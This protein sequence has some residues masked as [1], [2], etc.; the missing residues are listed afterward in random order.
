M[1]ARAFAARA[2]AAARA[3]PAFGARVAILVALL[4]LVLW[5]R[6]AFDHL[7]SLPGKAVLDAIEIKLRP[8][9]SIDLGWRELGQTPGPR[10]AESR[11]VRFGF[12]NGALRIANVARARR[13]SLGFA[14]ADGATL[15]VPAETFPIRAGQRVEIHIPGAV[16]GAEFQRGDPGRFIVS[17]ADGRRYVAEPDGLGGARWIDPGVGPCA[18]PT[19]IE[20]LRAEASAWGLDRSLAWLR[21]NAARPIGILALGGERDCLNRETLQIG[22]LGTARDPLPWRSLAVSLEGDVAFVG[23]FD[24]ARRSAAPAAFR[25]VDGASAD[26]PPSAT[27]LADQSW[28]ID[29]GGEWGALTHFVAGSTQYEV[30]KA[31]VA[32]DAAVIRLHPTELAELFEPGQCADEEARARCPRPLDEACA[33]GEICP[34]PR[35]FAA[36]PGA[37]DCDGAA[38]G[39]AICWTWTRAGNALADT[40]ARVRQTWDA[41][42][43]ITRLMFIGIALAL[44][45]LFAGGGYFLMWIAL[46]CVIAATGAWA[47][48]GAAAL[49]RA[50]IALLAAREY[51]AAALLGPAARS[52]ELASIALGAAGAAA[53]AA[54]ALAARE[55]VRRSRPLA[56]TVL[57]CGLAL[58]GEAAARLGAPLSPPAALDFMLANWAFAGVVL[59]LCEA[60]VSLGLFWLAAAALAMLGSLSLGLMALDASTTKFLAMSLKHRLLFLELIPPLAVAIGGAPANAL[61]RG[62]DR[63]AATDAPG[64][65]SPWRAAAALAAWL[66]SAGAWLGPAARALSPR[67]A[68]AS[69]V[70]RGRAFLDEA[71]DAGVFAMRW[72]IGFVLLGLMGLW[73]LSSSQ[74][75]LGEFQPVEFAKFAVVVVSARS[76]TM[77]WAVLTRRRAGGSA[78]GAL[79]AVAAAAAILGAGA[80]L[81]IAWLADIPPGSRQIAFAAG[82]LLLAAAAAYL[83][84]ARLIGLFLNFALLAAF[85]GV[86]IGVPS[87]LSD[88]SPALIMSIVFAT[89]IACFFVMLGYQAVASA[90]ARRRDRDLTPRVFK[91]PPRGDFAGLAGWT[92]AAALAVFVIGLGEW[93]FGLD[94]FRPLRSAYVL[95]TSMGSWRESRDERLDMLETAG[96]GSGRRVVVER[97][98]SW[99]DLALGTGGPPR[100]PRAN[101]P[102]DAAAPRPC[103]IDS[104]IQLVLSRRAVALAPRGLAPELAA[105]PFPVL[106]ALAAAPVRW[107][108]D[109]FGPRRSAPRASG[110]AVAPI[111]IPVVESDF[112]GA[113]LIGRMGFGAALAAFAAQLLFVAVPV[114]AMSGL[115]K[116]GRDPGGPRRDTARLLF[117]IT[118]GCASLFVMQWALSWANALGLAPVMGQPMTWSSNASSHHA[119]MALPCLLTFIAGARYARFD[120]FVYRPRDPP[121]RRG[122]A[123]A[124]RFHDG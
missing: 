115:A 72:G 94:A 34:F 91:A 102:A 54:L 17:T 61:R 4:A 64:G 48:P 35:D 71:A 18:A 2:F 46:S 41:R 3:A 116:G 99:E 21:S 69:V 76:L 97:F 50:V 20:S 113:Y 122:G 14:G 87:W 23:A 57:S 66:G 27:G 43:E 65:A 26:S 58:A 107:L 112:A 63:F 73:L 70:E 24:A 86:M 22:R 59:L 124:R 52:A 119:L 79:G 39:A 55:G 78:R 114:H 67:P 7:A 5:W 62:L 44:A 9:Q 81:L 90:S 15:T 68:P 121:P 33:A 25:R 80:G 118:A 93:R 11:H 98:L 31:D 10:S 8:G 32:S 77:S 49:H 6:D 92:L 103:Y 28:R 111:D 40:D 120:R 51:H 45:A 83:I 101:A 36:A 85:A 75:G 104:E 56:L 95:A 13:L 110:E 106:G 38:G 89:M 29:A 19:P 109:G 16:V 1:T 53:L 84:R 108:I 60:G 37:P 30:T 105:V 47:A 117:V 100:C 12:E 82:L 96:L 74:I 123:R 88:W 42:G